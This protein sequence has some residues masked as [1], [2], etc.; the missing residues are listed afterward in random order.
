MN[1]WFPVEHHTGVPLLHYLPPSLYRR[2]FRCTVL[3]Y[4]SHEANLNLL[5]GSSLRALFP[6]EYPVE[7]KRTGVRLGPFSSNLA[8][9]HRGSAVIG[10]RSGG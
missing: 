8:A 9:N 3:E 2:L 5:T 10:R 7:V 1:R 6:A 4:W